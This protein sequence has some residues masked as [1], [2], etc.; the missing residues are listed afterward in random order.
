MP[1]YAH[2]LYE[3]ASQWRAEGPAKAWRVWANRSFSGV[4][5]TT[6]AISRRRSHHVTNYAAVATSGRGR[7]DRF[8]LGQGTTTRGHGRT[9]RPLQ[10]SARRSPPH[11]AASNRS[12][13]L[14]SEL[15]LTHRRRTLGAAGRS[16]TSSMSSTTLRCEGLPSTP[17][18]TTIPIPLSN[19]RIRVNLPLEVSRATAV[20][21][22]KDITGIASEGRGV[23]VVVLAFTS[24]K[25]FASVFAD[26]RRELSGR[27]KQKAARVIRPVEVA[28]RAQKALHKCCRFEGDSFAASRS[29]IM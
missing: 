10:V 8:P 20:C 12:R 6:T 17:N 15:S 3:G 4:P 22:G 5:S 16:A 18:S 27:Q 29:G 23:E 21:A 9:A 1:P 7:L 19:V 14:I 2:A 26:S 28:L 25:W 11:A 13:H 24:M